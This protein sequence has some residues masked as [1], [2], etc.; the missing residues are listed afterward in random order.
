MRCLLVVWSVLALVAQASA[1]DCVEWNTLEFFKS[2]T[3]W[4]AI[5][6]IEAG[7]DVN[8]GYGSSTPLHL[9]ALHSAHPIVIT[10]LV[11]AGADVN[12]RRVGGST[13]LHDAQFSAGT[14]LALVD[15]GADVNARNLDGETPLH[16][17]CLTSPAA[18]LVLLVAGADVN[19]RDGR[20]WTPLYDAVAFR[21]SLTLIGALL[22]AGA[23]VNFRGYSPLHHA[24]EF[25]DNPA[26][27]ELLLAAGA[28]ASARDLD[29]K[30][31]WDYA[32][33]NEGLRGTDAWWRLREGARE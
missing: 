5:E 31:P 16:R 33:E 14:T 22:A 28:D 17:A 20:G 4:E 18:A 7:A 27:I 8:A 2:A 24:A 26:I 1:A 11:K 12:A 10:A 6:C 9:A 30:T 19:A 32:R 23:W 21:S 29:G 15:A 25:T 3:S 13:P